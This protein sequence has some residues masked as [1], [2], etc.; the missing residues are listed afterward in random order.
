MYTK[1]V[2]IFAGVRYGQYVQVDENFTR[3]RLR[4]VELDNLGRDLAWLII[5]GGLV[6]LW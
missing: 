2:D 3:T 6:L 4:H 1:S 5:D